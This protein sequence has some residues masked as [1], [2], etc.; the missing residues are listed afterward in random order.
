MDT[1]HFDLLFFTDRV[2]KG[3]ASLTAEEMHHAM[4]VMRRKVGD[5]L[6]FTDGEGMLY[7]GRIA[8]V[9]KKEA[10]L[11]IIDSSEQ[12]TAAFQLSIAV[13]PT[14]SF[15]RMEWC[16]EKLT[17][18][19][20]HEF[21]PMLCERSERVRWNAPRVRKIMLSAMKQS[22]RAYLPQ[23]G[24]PQR[25]SD[26]ILSASPGKVRYI[27]MQGEKS[28]A[29]ARHYKPGTD[30]LIL[31]GPEGDF[32]AKEIAM[33]TEAGFVPLSLGEYRLRTE[34]AA[35]VAATTINALNQT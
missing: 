31:I 18:I 13:A 11:D 23:C 7:T 2:S 12:K 17:E 30:V 4:T 15:D 14:K 27:A 3:R 35:V 29:A 1:S 26:I 28:V 19:G 34:T 6:T 16:I 9:G 33:A 8:E 22:K 5:I 32:T 25:F 20:V 21:I 24:M 10:W